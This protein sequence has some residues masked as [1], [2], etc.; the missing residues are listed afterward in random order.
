MVLEQFVDKNIE[1]SLSYIV[2]KISSLNQRI[3]Q[4]QHIHFP[5]LIKLYQKY[6]KNNPT[7]ENFKILL[8]IYDGN[9]QEFLDEYK[10]E[11]LYSINKKTQIDYN[12]YLSFIKVFYFV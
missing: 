7:K 8:S 10:Y 4:S 12:V 5:I 3:F 1:K 11:T 6:V 2:E 9:E